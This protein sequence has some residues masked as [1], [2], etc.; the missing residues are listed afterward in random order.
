MAGS[1]D[2]NRHG[3]HGDTASSGNL[4]TPGRP[5]SHKRRR[6]KRCS[7]S[8]SSERSGDIESPTSATESSSKPTAPKVRYFWPPDHVLTLINWMQT[9]G[10][11]FEDKTKNAT[12]CKNEVFADVDEITPKRIGE[13]WY[14]LR[15]RYQKAVSHGTYACKSS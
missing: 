1:G 11:L 14:R 4:T 8:M 6:Y 3:K 15:D 5:Y 10:D 13:K 2:E 7:R 9:R 12:I